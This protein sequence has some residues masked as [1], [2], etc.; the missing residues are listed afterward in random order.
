[1][2]IRYKMNA[3]N[4]FS[5]RD[6]VKR[7]QYGFTFGGP[8]LLPNYYNGKNKTFFFVSYQGAP[9]R[10][11]VPG[12][13]RT[14]PSDAMK[15]GDFSSFL[16]ANGVG[17]VHD[18]LAPSTYFPNNRLPASRFDPVSRKLLDYIPSSSDPNYFLRFGTPVTAINDSQILVRGDQMISTKQRLSG[19]LFR[20][21]YDRPWVYIPSNLLY[22]NP[23][24]FGSATSMTVNH[25]Y[26]ISS[27]TMNAL[28]ATFHQSTPKAAPPPGLDISYEKLGSRMKAVPGYPTMDLGISN[29]SGIT[30]GLGYYGPQASYQLG[31][32]FSYA[33]GKHNM[34]IGGELKRYRLDIASYWLSGGTISFNGQMLSDPGRVNAGN[35][36]A[37]FLLGTAATLR[38]QSFWSSRIYNWATALYFQDDI[39]LTSKLTMNVGVRWDPRFDVNEIYKKRMTWIP[40]R[41]SEV[42]PNAPK[43]LIF[44]RDRGYEDRIIPTQW[45]VIAPRL[46][47]AYQVRPRT[48]IRAAYGIFYD[49][50]MSIFNNRTAAGQPFVV[51]ENLTGPFKFSDPYSGRAVLEPTPVVPG[52]EFQFSPYGTWAVPGTN[53][54]AGYLQNWNFVVEQQLRGDVLVRT[55]YVASKGTRLLQSPEVNPGIFGPGATSANIN[56]RRPYQPVGGLQVGQATAWSKYQSAQFTVQKRFS[57]GF[58]I[59]ANYTISK[60]TDIT[61]YATIE[62]NSTGPDPFNFNNN[63]GL[64]DF[65]TPQR[66]V[67]SGIVEH[68]K[69]QSMHPA[70]RLVLGGWQSNF[71]YTAQS[72]T[73]INILS[74]VD[75][76]LTGVGGN[77]ADLT[78][79]SLTLPGGR[80]RGDQIQ[81]W[82]NTKA[83]KVNA[84]GT[85]GQLGRN[86]LRSPGAWNTD[87]SLFKEVRPTERAKVQFRGEFF[88][89]FNHTRLGGPNTTVVS[90][91]F[92]RITSAYEPRIVQLGLKLIF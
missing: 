36:F 34:R 83:F 62:G 48:V 79:E 58:S 9:Y 92:G 90:T 18:P 80:S 35:S 55:A 73:P 14:A 45:G 29:W 87:Y 6:A 39:R 77:R 21:H 10:Q 13:L 78:G 75:N 91:A 85:V 37:E 74:G 70:A 64:S 68:P 27:R 3:A 20:L 71:I 28:T 12:A 67:I 24:Q 25:D 63:R 88:N 43:G 16:G 59:L 52:K 7:N 82:F 84:I 5:G 26:T 40:G 15:S 8:V 57:H 23:G 32:T 60:S 65:D 51:Q 89:L 76:A 42:Y 1:M 11:A 38:Q 2:N 50:Y 46:G 49:S 47:L 41:Q 69:F 22:V 17:A 54:K 56:L 61:S 66:V 53:M 4:F 30:L 31:D 72:G 44:E 86:R 81:S 19:R 33:T